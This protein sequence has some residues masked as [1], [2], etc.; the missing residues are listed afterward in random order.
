MHPLSFL[1]RSLANESFA[2]LSYIVLAAV[3]LALGDGLVKL[4]ADQ[5]SVWQLIVLR[6]VVAVPLLGV[7]MVSYARRGLRARHSFWI[8]V[9]SLLLVVMWVLV[10]LALT[11][12]ALPTVSAALYTAP[13]IIT[14]LCALEPGRRLAAGEIG[15]VVLG[16]IGVLV[17]LRPGSSAFSPMLWLPLTGA[18]LYAL[19][20]LI[21]ATKCRDE[22]PLVMSMGVQIAF[23][24]VGLVALG[25]FAMFD[26]PATWQTV[27]PFVARGWPSLDGVDLPYLGA[28]IV[29]LAVIAVVASAAMGRAYQMAPAPLVAA[30]DYSYLVFS[31]LWGFLLFDHLPDRWG[32][33]GMALIAV[34]GLYA[35]RS[36]PTDDGN[37]EIDRSDASVKDKS[38]G[39]RSRPRR[40]PRARSRRRRRPD[41]R[42][43]RR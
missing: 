39:R 31:T 11:G 8:G 26:M 15:A 40:P 10:Y 6:A 13:L 12:L 18:V 3:V 17:L 14:V 27:A 29:A 23:L 30:G 36:G 2:G 16:F 35:T 32:V 41:P 22:S 34:A 24:A 38:P 42:G 1:R 4:A 33:I 28:L 19:A 9:R 43:P 25:V 5:I 21:T 37:N 7:F 20:A